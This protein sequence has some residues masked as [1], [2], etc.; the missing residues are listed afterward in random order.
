[1]PRTEMIERERERERKI[2]PDLIISKSRAGRVIRSLRG[3][4]IE[5]VG[6]EPMPG[7]LPGG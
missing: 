1:M 4:F 7:S 6:K 5:L 3:S 2:L